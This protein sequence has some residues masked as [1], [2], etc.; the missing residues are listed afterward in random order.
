MFLLS[1]ATKPVQDRL[2]HRVDPD[3]YDGSIF[4]A[5]TAVP[6]TKSLSKSSQGKVQSVARMT[7]S[8]SDG[9]VQGVAGTSGEGEGRGSQPLLRHSS[10]EEE[11]E[12]PA[13]SV[14]L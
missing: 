4:L 7:A 12:A 3:E 1:S 14:S 10:Q 11:E 9:R 2:L 13:G 8:G 6:S 5:D